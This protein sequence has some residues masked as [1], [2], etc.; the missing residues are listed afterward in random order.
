[1]PPID[2][3]HRAYR[4]SCIE[5]ANALGWDRNSIADWFE[6]FMFMRMKEQSFSRNLAAWQAMRDVRA[7]FDKAGSDFS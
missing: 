2:R 1:L 5:F 6:Q 3:I 7:F 4:D